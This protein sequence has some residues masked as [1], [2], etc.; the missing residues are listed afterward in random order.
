V[1]ELRGTATGVVSA[2]VDQCF[3]LLEAVD[4]YPSWYPE[5]VREATVVESNPDGRPT[6]VH[7]NLHVSHGLIVKDFMLMLAVDVERPSTVTLSRIPSGPSDRQRFAVT[8]RLEDEGQTR[9]RLEL[10]ANLSVPRL[11]PVGG[12]GEAMAEGFVSAATRAL[13][14]SPG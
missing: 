8:W 10:D 7:T 3:A 12:I 6:K 5:V 9:I 11:V 1:K 14:E 2:P 13:D 4:G